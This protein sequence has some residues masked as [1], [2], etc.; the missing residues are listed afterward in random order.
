MRLRPLRL[1]EWK[2]RGGA[3]LGLSGGGGGGAV[4]GTTSAAAISMTDRHEHSKNR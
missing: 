3:K 4:G 1:P 2:V